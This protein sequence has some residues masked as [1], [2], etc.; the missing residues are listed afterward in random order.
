LLAARYATACKRPLLSL[1]L[2]KQPTR[3]DAE[4][5]TAADVQRISQL[6]DPPHF[7]N[8]GFNQKFRA[9]PAATLPVLL[10]R[11]SVELAAP[12]PSVR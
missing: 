4:L 12:F 2:S 3:A 1:A 8:V 10:R 5:A 9:G 6:D 7:P 11:G